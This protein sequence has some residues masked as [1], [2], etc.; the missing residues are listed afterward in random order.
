[1]NRINVSKEGAR[2]VARFA[3]DF[4]TK[5]FVKSLGWRFDPAKKV[6]YTED[7]VT[8]AKLD[9]AA[10]D[11]VART[12]EASRAADAA[13][14]IPAPAGL[15]YFPFQRAGIA[16]ALPQNGEFFSLGGGNLFRGMGL[17]DRQGNA[18]WVGSV[19]WRIPV[20]RDGK[21]VGIVSRRNVLQAV[22]SRMQAPALHPADRSIRETFYAKLAAEAWADGSSSINA[23][24]SDGV[25]HLWGYAPEGALHQAIVVLAESIPGVRRVEDHLEEPPVYDPLDRPHWQDWPVRQ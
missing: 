18:F 8:A 13:I 23:I 15:S 14:D 5:D 9:P 12:V 20:L 3:F 1:M 17:A 25:L 4:A 19:E 2:W 10:A 16:F 21:L 22:A 7:P 11:K 24:V 6:W